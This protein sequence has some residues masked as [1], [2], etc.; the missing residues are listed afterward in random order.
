MNRVCVVVGGAGLELEALC[1][2]ERGNPERE[3]AAEIPSVARDLLN[4]DLEES[5]VG[6]AGLEPAASSL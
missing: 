1:R 5:M 2:R 4:A 3:P 6:G